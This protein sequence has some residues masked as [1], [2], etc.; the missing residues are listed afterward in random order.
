MKDKIAMWS[1]YITSVI[2]IG[3]SCMLAMVA[4][5]EMGVAQEIEKK[6]DN[7]VNEKFEFQAVGVNLKLDKRLADANNRLIRL[8]NNYLLGPKIIEE[9][10]KFKQRR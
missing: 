4:S 3:F 6:I 2:L 9:H 5:N 10:K 7:L 8:E 1:I